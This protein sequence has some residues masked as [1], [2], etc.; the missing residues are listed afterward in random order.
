MFD[1]TEN[2]LKL[3]S[4]PRIHWIQLSSDGVIEFF[5][6]NHM[7]QTWR[8]CEARGYLEFVEGWS[9]QGK[10]W[11]LDFGSVVHKLMEIYYVKRY[12]PNFDIHAFCLNTVSNVWK[13]F[14]LDWYGN[15]K[16]PE[17]GYE[18]LGGLLGL[19]SLMTGYTTMYRYDT[20]RFRV[21]GSELL[22]GKSKEVPIYEPHPLAYTPHNIYY[23][24]F[25]FRL[26]LSGK[27]DLLLDDGHT[28]GPMDHKTFG[29]F[30]GNPL[31]TYELNDGLTGYIYASQYLV[32]KLQVE[33]RRDV[34][35]IWMNMI[36]VKP[37]DPKL[38][39]SERFKR[40]PLLKTSQQLEQYRE[41]QLSTVK[42]IFDL[43]SYPGLITPIFDTFICNNYMHR[44]CSF[45]NVH[46]QSSLEDQKKMLE[47]NFVRRE[48]L[49]NPEEI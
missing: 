32:R 38:P 43:L 14:D 30:R 28:I 49:W 31:T 11:F 47:A 33:G 48:K 45:F 44:Q 10:I 40:M 1:Y 12:D 4:D 29:Y 21:I 6:D 36:Q 20:E 41:R 5:M 8:A 25:P 46:R 35:K 22:F 23:N 3:A 7:L 17:K 13:E 26:Y 16:P 34:N 37:T 18:E 24:V 19:M 39:L 2:I 42:R 15:Q 27:I 9:A